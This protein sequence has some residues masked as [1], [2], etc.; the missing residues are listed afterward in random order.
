MNKLENIGFDD[1]LKHHGIKGQKWGVKNG[2]PYPINSE[3]SV[4]KNY[5]QCWDG[6]LIVFKI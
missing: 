5:E 6:N 4:E 1:E 2:P 3:K